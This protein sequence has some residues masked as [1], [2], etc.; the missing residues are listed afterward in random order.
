LSTNAPNEGYTKQPT[1]ALLNGSDVYHYDFSFGAVRHLIAG[2]RANGQKNVVLAMKDLLREPIE[3]V[4]PHRK[5]MSA[6]VDLPNMWHVVC[7]KIGMQPL[8]YV[9]EPILVAAR[10][11]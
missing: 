4:F 7:L 3:I 8:P 1:E 9:D 6:L 11:P 2:N 5:H 10:N